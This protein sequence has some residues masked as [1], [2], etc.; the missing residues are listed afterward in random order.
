MDISSE[1]TNFA[2]L[3][4]SLLSSIIYKDAEESQEAVKLLFTYIVMANLHFSVNFQQMIYF[5]SGHSPF[6]ATVSDKLKHWIRLV[7]LNCISV[8]DPT[9]GFTNPADCVATF[10]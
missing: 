1:D 10:T 2:L 3:Y 7:K 9:V 8:T 6:Y 5:F 4:L